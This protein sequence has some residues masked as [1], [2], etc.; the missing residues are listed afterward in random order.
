MT[1]QTVTDEMRNT[2]K[3][4]VAGLATVDLNV[5]ITALVKMLAA[6]KVPAT[7]IDG[8]RELLQIARDELATRPDRH[9]V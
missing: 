7:Q 4:Q 2:L 5:K 6:G 3:A 8:A 1:N 9:L